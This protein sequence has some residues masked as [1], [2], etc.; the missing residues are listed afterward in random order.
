MEILELKITTEKKIR[1]HGP[2]G[3]FQLVQETV[4]VKLGQSIKIIQSEKHKG[5]IWGGK[6]RE[7]QSYTSTNICTTATLEK[8]EKGKKIY[9]KKYS[10]QPPKFDEKYY[11]STKLDK[12]QDEYTQVHYI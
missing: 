2:K 10:W 1:Q 7:H 5:K 6:W 8:E 3:R 12:F 9:W 11:T 4:N